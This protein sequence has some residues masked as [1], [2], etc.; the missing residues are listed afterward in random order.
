ML[1]AFA[2]LLLFL[3]ALLFDTDAFALR[4]SFHQRTS[5]T[6]MVRGISTTTSFLP[7]TATGLYAEKNKKPKN[8]SSGGEDGEKPKKK[9]KKKKRKYFPPKA[10]N[11]SDKNKATT[12]KKKMKKTKK[13]K[14]TGIS[15]K[16]KKEKEEVVAKVGKVAKELRAAKQKGQNKQEADGDGSLLDIVNPFKAGK[17]FRQT[18]DSLAKIG[19]STSDRLTDEQR[20]I[21]YISDRLV[22][23][24]DQPLFSEP[25][26]F[27][28]RL[29]R[30]DYIPEVL[31]VGAT[32]EVGRRVTQRLL[33]DGRFRVRVLVR[34]LYSKTLNLLG[35][36]VTYCQGDL[37]N[38]ESLEYSVTDVDKIVYCAAPPR[39][40]E[41]DFRE[42][43][44]EYTKENMP[45]SKDDVAV[46]AP[47]EASNDEKVSSNAEWERLASVLELRSKLAEQVDCVGMENLVRAYQNVRFADYGTSQ[48]AKRSLFKFSSRQEDFNL[49]AIDEDQDQIV[50]EAEEEEPVAAAS[51]TPT[52][53]RSGF[54]SPYD[55]TYDDY[56]D[57]PYADSDDDYYEG[58]ADTYKDDEF[59][60]QQE[61]Q[62][63]KSATT[64]A[65][66]VWMKNKFDLAVF[67]GRVPKGRG[68]GGTLG[69]EAAVVSSRLRSRER[70]EE[71]IDLSSGFGGFIARMC[72]DGR[73]YEAFVRTGLYETN[74]VE[75]VC[76]F[77]T[78]T[79]PVRPDNKSSNKFTTVR[80]AYDNFV[81]IQTKKKKSGGGSDGEASMSSTSSSVA[82]FRGK[83][84]RQ[85]GFRYRADS[86][87]EWNKLETGA[88]SS[89]YMALSYI[90]VF[91]SQPEPEFIYLSDARIPP[92]VTSTMVKHEARQLVLVDPENSSDGD[93]VR[94]MDDAQL[95]SAIE[96]TQGRSE[97][98][99]YF[100][101]RGEEI[102]KKSGLSYA[103]LRVWG[104][105]ED[106]S[107]DA[108]SL[109]LRQSF[110]EEDEEEGGG[111]EALEGEEEVVREVSRADVAQVCASALLEP[112][113]LNKSFYLSK[114]KARSSAMVDAEEELSNKFSRVPV[115]TAV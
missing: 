14:G 74:G 94:I 10:S 86:N 55:E 33:L 54:K 79:K 31:V 4:P 111:E 40:D 89:F 92:K 96:D 45:D 108:T 44:K 113:A 56:S 52:T 20:S 114:S 13:K 27:L 2:S 5:S 50:E 8:S 60:D 104:Y 26:P 95:Q 67:V 58:M 43:F 100:K 53:T 38:I 29:E 107:G 28:E 24:Q 21:Y 93:A 106:P 1:P 36:G 37:S 75:Y 109:T 25:N 34:D 9:K 61:A 105:N 68:V 91:R 83:D 48:T 41:E 63:R 77:R 98:E 73:Q 78:D 18:I 12:T 7:R 39:P 47:D 102:L 42:R 112:N 11:S 76:E 62:G 15:G 70:P 19:S 51:S 99:T 6:D 49:F 46:T 87:P 23:Q 80:L 17:K 66:C 65:Q 16:S 84:V 72:S 81:P 115:D 59:D 85:I 69:G 3:M 57:D 90:K 103:I 101:W 30:E 64:K 110:E 22:E 71:G 35:P 97:E 88:Y 32:G 82:P